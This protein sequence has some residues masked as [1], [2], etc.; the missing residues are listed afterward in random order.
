MT[1]G[2]GHARARG[3]RRGDI[4]LR[5]VAAVP[6]GYATSSL[7]A[8]AIA[9][10]LPGDRAEASVTASLIALVLC[11]VAAMWSFAARSGWRAIWTLAAAGAAAGAIA[12][13]SIDATGRL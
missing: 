10:M 2:D 9:R 12:W 7:W 3:A 13:G 11:A 8:M 1:A 6:L 4:A 5:I